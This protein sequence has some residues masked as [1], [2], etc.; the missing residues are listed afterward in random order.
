MGFL[1]VEWERYTKSHHLFKE[2][3][4]VSEASGKT[5]HKKNIPVKRATFSSRV[6]CFNSVSISAFAIYA[7]ALST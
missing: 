4:V 2:M 5:T 1:A 3:E 7:K 6:S